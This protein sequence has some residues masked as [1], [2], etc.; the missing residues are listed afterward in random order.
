MVQAVLVNR[1]TASSS[2]LLAAAL[3]GGRGAHLVGETTVGKG[4][5]QRSI[6]LKVG[7]G[8]GAEPGGATLVVS[9]TRFEGAGRERLEEG[10]LSV[11]TACEVEAVEEVVYEGGGVEDL[12]LEEDVCVRL[13]M[14]WLD[15]AR[16]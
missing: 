15:G 12:G 4:R 3:R 5:S 14:Q 11:G 1:A 2:E 7:G 9:V 16:P 13:G 8:T 6:P 10:G